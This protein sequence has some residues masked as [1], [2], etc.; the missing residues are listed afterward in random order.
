MDSTLS[1]DEVDALLAAVKTGELGEEEQAPDA[2]KVEQVKVVTYNFRKPQL[3]SGDQNRSLQ[4]IHETFAKGVQSSMLTNLKAPLE[5]KPIS[6]DYLTYNEFV[7]SLMSPTFIMVLSGAPVMGE[8][9]IEMDMSIVLMVINILLGGDSGTAPEPRELT[10]IEASIAGPLVDIV[11]GELTNA[12]SNTVNVKFECTVIEYN[13]EYVRVVSADSSVLSTTMDLRLNEKTGAMNIC[14][15]IE[16]IL[17]VLDILTTRVTGGRKKEDVATNQ[18]ATLQ[19]MRKVPIELRAEV[20]R[21]SI[22]TSQLGK[23]K[24]GDVLCLNKRFDVPVDVYIGKRQCFHA[25]L[26][27][28]RDK[29]AVKLLERIREKETNQA[30]SKNKTGKA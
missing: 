20:G 14:Y 5:I 9:V 21:C 23:L 29:V 8:L 2:R 1:Q 15:P 27:K 25:A 19:A 30:S 28:Q 22:L 18:I 6:L 13:P 17:P 24:P 7:L 4:F 11:A 26:Q 12:W 16:T 3:M 10:A